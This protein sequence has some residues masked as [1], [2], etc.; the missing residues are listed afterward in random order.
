MN[1]ILLRKTFRDLR[2]SLATTSALA[3][4]LLL[5]VTSYIALVGAYRDLATSYDHTYD[6]LHFADVTFSMEGAPESVA[7][8][9]AALGGIEAVTG[10]LII[11]AGLEQPPSGD[12]S[13]DAEPIRSRLIGI[14]AEAHPQVNDV[15]VDSGRYFLPD[16]GRSV[17]LETHFA[18]VYGLGA[19]DV[20]TPILD[21]KKLDFRVVGVAASPEYLIVSPSTQE[22]ITTARTFAVLFVP[23]KTLQQLVSQEGMI[24]D[25]SVRLSPGADSEKTVKAIQEK[26]QPYGLLATTLQKNQ[27]SNNALRADLD[28]YKEI[29]DAMP[30]II[31]LVAAFS[32]FITLGRQVRAQQPQIGL[33]KALGY[34][35][36][37]VMAHYLSY[38]LIIGFI[39]SLG[40]VLLG[41][42]MVGEI[43]SEYAT[44][45]GIPLVQT[46]FYADL[47]WQGVL[48]SLAVSFLAGLQPAFSSSRMAPAAAMRQDPA[49]A[50]VKGRASWLDKLF[51]MP[52]DWRLAMRNVFRVRRRSFS[53]I[54]GIV[55]AFILILMTWGMLDSMSYL[56]DQNF[57]VIPRWDQ[58]AVFNAPQPA[59]VLDQIRNLPGV[60][61]AEPVI[62]LPATLKKD[63]TEKDILLTAISR[64]QKMIDWQMTSGGTASE[65]LAGGRLILTKAMAK[66]LKVTVGDS[67]TLTTLAGS[68][69]FVLGG[70]EDEM[71][72]GAAYLSLDS[73]LS[74]MG[75]P[76]PVFNGVY[77]TTEPSQGNA[78]RKALYNLPG[79]AGVQRRAD[80]EADW[81]SLMSFY[82]VFMG[83]LFLFAGG[84]AF[85]VLFNAM[86]I[87]VLERQ[88]EL[89]TL[90][91][92][93][94][95]P[96]RIGFLLVLESIVLWL[97][98]IVPGI[99]AG[100]LV[101][102]EMAGLF[103][104]DLFSIPVVIFPSSYIISAA[105][106]LL[107][108]LLAA[109]PAI[110]KVNRLNLAEATKLLT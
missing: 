28:G 62:Q 4:I 96:G 43:T 9:I 80:T 24:N 19:D 79:T 100:Y 31:L 11:D 87:N 50:L 32:V 7:Q 18:E 42:L 16:D 3:F 81:R 64:D 41:S 94:T 99:L 15:M 33:M 69:T 54:L 104:T 103:Q 29:A 46:R 74:W 51:P 34:S 63:G 47:V 82:Y 17:L 73:I 44:E 57:E 36:G 59:T 1:I 55:F 98:S 75:A 27:P 40:G 65:A 101:A 35:R 86:T 53:S 61:S 70:T 14:P 88:R 52:V 23:L 56:L 48:L 109:W 6:M 66:Q 22:M 107:T 30:G 93:G 108:M 49:T 21:G 89:A 12:G 5:G 106:I 83:V 78:V 72:S 77:L 45:L 110:R 105:A 8:D 95:G 67:I 102:L 20:V 25:V 2:A 68:K 26:L 85:A 13:A 39:G 10:R 91:A 97:M 76:A 92:I 58:F 84:M 37:A 90:R 38:S 60:R 71:M